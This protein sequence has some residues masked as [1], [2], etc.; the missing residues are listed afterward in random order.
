MSQAR[1]PAGTP[2]GGQFAPTNRPEAAGVQLVDDDN[3][4]SA[5][6]V[7][8]GL[9][10]DWE[11][12]RTQ[13]ARLVELADPRSE[14]GGDADLAGIINLL[15]DIQNQAA[16]VL[17]EQA[18][19]GKMEDG[20][21]VAQYDNNDDETAVCDE[22]GEVIE[23]EL[24]VDQHAV[25]CSLHPGNVVDGPAGALPHAD[26]PRIESSG[27][28]DEYRRFLGQGSRPSPSGE[29]PV[30]L[31]AHLLRT[32]NAIP[33]MATTVADKLERQHEALRGI[34][35]L[36]SDPQW[37]SPADRLEWIATLIE[38]AGYPPEAYRPEFSEPIEL[39]L[40]D[41]TVVGQIEL[42][43]GDETL[44]VPSAGGRPVRVATGA[45]EWDRDGQTWFH[46][47]EDPAAV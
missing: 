9:N 13:K 2:V 47:P 24:A 8:V 4:A 35:A 27:G 1:R 23:S 22:C 20:P 31:Q 25:W 34:Q 21:D 14:L 18:V 15:D 17:G 41:R 16:E 30:R 37:D 39:Q 5:P 7:P 32:H 45:I 46:A 26:D 11:Q 43:D 40:E 38:G 42:V 6:V 29:L 33:E 28:L 12:L 10:V 3:A 36:L 44:V 19:F